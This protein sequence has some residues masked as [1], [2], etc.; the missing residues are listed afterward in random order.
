[1]SDKVLP[2]SGHGASAW[3]RLLGQAGT[4]FHLFS[5]MGG[6]RTQE[7]KQSGRVDRV[8]EETSVSEETVF[9]VKWDRSCLS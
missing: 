5:D 4:A 7:D 6:K 2:M 3:L 9:L 8:K 1:M